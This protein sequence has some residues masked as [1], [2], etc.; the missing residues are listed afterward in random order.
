M[1]AAITNKTRIMITLMLII[2]SSYQYSEDNLFLN[3]L[4]LKYEHVFAQNV[5][6]VT[7][8]IPN[9]HLVVNDTLSSTPTVIEMDI[10]IDSNINL[11]VPLLRKNPNVFLYIKTFKT[12]NVYYYPNQFYISNMMLYMCLVVIHHI[13]NHY[14][15]PL[16]V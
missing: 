1:E 8:T 9:H 10:E 14:R 12:V 2:L 4:S 7:D 11:T 3:L 16:F 5:P 15:D 13:N 6:N